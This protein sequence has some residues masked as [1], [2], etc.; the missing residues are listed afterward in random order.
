MSAPGRLP[1]RPSKPSPPPTGSEPAPGRVEG[2]RAQSLQQEPWPRRAEH[3]P[4]TVAGR[5]SQDV[6]ARHREVLP[7]RPGPRSQVPGTT[8]DTGSRRGAPGGPEQTPLRG[9]PDV[10]VTSDPVGNG[11]RIRRSAQQWRSACSGRPAAP[12]GG[13]VAGD[14][15]VRL[16]DRCRQRHSGPEGAPPGGRGRH[17][18]VRPDRAG[19]GLQLRDPRPPGVSGPGRREHSGSASAP[20]TAGS[21]AVSAGS[22]PSRKRRRSAPARTTP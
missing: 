10:N 21:H 17:G 6:P 7:V 22:P 13:A 9:G 5:H 11:R 8:P 19:R 14:R 18:P 16:R 1:F 12:G 3:L 2:T 20:P 4:P 15:P